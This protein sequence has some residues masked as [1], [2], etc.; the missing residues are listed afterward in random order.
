MFKLF[1]WHEC[2]HLIWRRCWMEPMQFISQRLAKIIRH[3]ALVY[4]YSSW[5]LIIGFNSLHC[6]YPLFMHYHQQWSQWNLWTV[7][8]IYFV[9]ILKQ[10]HDTCGHRWP[11]SLVPPPNI[12]VNYLECNKYLPIRFWFAFE[13]TI[14]PNNL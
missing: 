4:M 8:S 9:F 11:N 5:I 2:L 1:K 7:L 14:L 6:L 13:V 12:I 10:L 3:W